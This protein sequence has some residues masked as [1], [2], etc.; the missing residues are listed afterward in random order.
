[1]QAAQVPIGFWV[2]AD[3]AGSAELE[4]TGFEDGSSEG[5]G[6]FGETLAVGVT[7]GGVGGKG[8]TI[9]AVLDVPAQGDALRAEGVAVEEAPLAEALLG[10]NPLLLGPCAAHL[11]EVDGNL[12]P[13][14]VQ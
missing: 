7:Q 8:Q 1:M 10:A 4:K 11:E 6:E 3:K 12:P 9:G 14:G 13:G 5:A 2:R